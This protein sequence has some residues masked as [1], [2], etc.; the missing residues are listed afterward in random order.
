M[1]RQ[2]QD[3][4]ELFDV[5]NAFYIG[6]YQQAINEALSFNVSNLCPSI[7]TMK[8]VI[9]TVLHICFGGVSRHVSVHVLSNYLQKTSLFYIVRGLDILNSS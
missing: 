2:Q 5:K 4:D 9:E 8:S 3:V 6:N 1:A 7:L